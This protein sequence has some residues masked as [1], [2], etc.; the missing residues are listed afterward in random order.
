MREKKNKSNKSKKSFKY[1][2]SKLWL[3]IPNEI[4][5]QAIT[6]HQ[7][8]FKSKFYKN[9]L[10]CQQDERMK[11]IFNIIDEQELEESLFVYNI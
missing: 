9:L 6:T 2:A 4:T 11:E 3:N 5:Y 7:N 1:R 8:V 10:H